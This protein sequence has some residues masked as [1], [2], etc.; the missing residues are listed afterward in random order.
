MSSDLSSQL[1]R[2]LSKAA[3][4][5]EVNSA[6]KMRISEL[7]DQVAH[8]QEVLSALQVEHADFQEQL[9][10]RNLAMTVQSGSPAR[11]TYSEEKIA[12]LIREIDLPILA[13]FCVK[14]NEHVVMTLA[15]CVTS[16]PHLFEG[17]SLQWKV[18]AQR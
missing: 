7:E 2:V 15:R 5:V 13:V 1:E 11:D 8:L 4:V 14:L 3:K 6:L 10:Q 17:S 16:R 9:Q 18:K 12:E